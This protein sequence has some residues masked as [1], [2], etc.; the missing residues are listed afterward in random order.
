ME[1]IDDADKDKVMAAFQQV[2][3]IGHTQVEHLAV[4]KS[5]KRLPVLA[6]ATRIVVE[7]EEYLI[8]LTIEIS[9]LV[10][11]R[12]KIQ[13]QVKEIFRLN[14]LLKAENI[15]LKD[16]LELTGERSEIIG[17]SESIKYELFKI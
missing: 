7:G 8:G 9:E 13:E 3:T 14:E 5:G 15:Y 11:A 10:V 16:Q 2:F 12:E 17:V 6:N 1:F 4:A